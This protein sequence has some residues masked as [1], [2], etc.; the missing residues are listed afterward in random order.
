MLVGIWVVT[1]MERKVTN[2]TPFW[3]Q[4]QLILGKE[5]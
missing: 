3:R 1:K 5:D 2:Y 4:Y